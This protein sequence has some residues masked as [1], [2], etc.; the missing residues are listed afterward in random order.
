MVQNQFVLM[1]TIKKSADNKD[2]WPEKWWWGMKKRDDR[3]MR[4]CAWCEMKD[5]EEGAIGGS[6]VIQNKALSCCWLTVVARPAVVVWVWLIVVIQVHCLHRNM[7]SLSKN[8]NTF[9]IVT[10]KWK[11]HQ[12]VWGSVWAQLSGRKL[13]GLFLQQKTDTAVD[14]HW[15]HCVTLQIQLWY[16]VPAL[17]FLWVL[18]NINSCL[19]SCRDC[20]ALRL[21]M[22]FQFYAFSNA[23]G[24]C[25]MSETKWNKKDPA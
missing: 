9:M 6:G 18:L 17:Q 19:T 1:V 11:T 22:F 8:A 23:N 24:G 14:T 15:H 21:G 4:V 12:G 13:N 3:G 7:M 25:W 16:L 20:S 5:G 2:K 10:C